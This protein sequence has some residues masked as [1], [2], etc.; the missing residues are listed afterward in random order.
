MQNMTLRFFLDPISQGEITPGAI[1]TLIVA[2]GFLVGLFFWR[3]KQRSDHR[4][5]KLETVGVRNHL[6]PVEIKL[7][8]TFYSAL[9]QKTQES[10]LS[11]RSRFWQLLFHFSRAQMRT[12][13]H[14][15]L[16]LIN[17]IFPLASLRFA[18][19]RFE[20]IQPGELI[21]VVMAPQNMLAI[22]K[23]LDRPRSRISLAFCDKSFSISDPKK[24]SLFFYR[25]GI[26]SST[27]R[28]V[29]YAG[30]AGHAFFEKG[31]GLIAFAEEA[32][33]SAPAKAPRRMRANGAKSNLSRSP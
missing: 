7:L 25:K 2:A 28:G 3:R 12:H 17:K 14:G 18:I 32:P 29:L 6:S 11:D 15:M 22:V 23:R 26:G 31:D 5:G 27:V 33:L 20:D 8:G 4:M 1:A 10:L 13:P 19:T 9:P 24:A 21:A 30:P 16:R